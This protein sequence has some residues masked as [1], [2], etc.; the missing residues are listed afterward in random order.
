M[1]TK[2]PTNKDMAYYIANINAP[3]SNIPAPIIPS[4]VGVDTPASG[5]VAGAGV[6]V[7]VSV[8]WATLGVDVGVAVAVLVLDG[9]TPG[10]LLGLADGELAGEPLGVAKLITKTS[11]ACISL[12]T[13][14]L[15]SPGATGVIGDVRS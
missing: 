15:E 9:D 1:N 11:Q 4:S 6:E 2:N 14:A 7:G 8:A 13:D 12:P 3:K 10:E 5:R